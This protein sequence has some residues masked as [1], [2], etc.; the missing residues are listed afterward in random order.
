MLMNIKLDEYGIAPQRAH[1]TD[2]GVDLFAPFAFKVKAGKR[3][4]IDT[5]V[6]VVL[7]KNTVGYIK[8]KSG[9]MANKGILTD[10]TIDEGYTGQIGVV[11]FNFSDEDVVFEK[12]DKIAQ[13]VVQPVL[14]PGMII[15]DELP[16]TER[17][18]D[19]WG[20]TGR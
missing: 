13:L 8:S 5:G 12:G 4:V 6:H 19:G 7:P 14:Y 17:G 15:T 2:A 11:L 3:I 18:G 20:S 9:L 1:G 10:G 16:E